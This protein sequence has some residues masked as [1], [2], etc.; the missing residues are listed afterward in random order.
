MDYYEIDEF[1]FSEQ[2]EE[3]I[4]DGACFSLPLPFENTNGT[5]VEKFFISAFDYEK[6]SELPFSIL[7]CDCKLG[8]IIQ[9]R[10]LN[11][12]EKEKIKKDEIKMDINN[13]KKHIKEIENFRQLYCK[14]KDF[15]YNKELTDEEINMLSVFYKSLLVINEKE[16]LHNYIVINETFFQW[17]KNFSRKE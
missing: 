14:V 17:M 9:Y 12:W 4:K 13:H 16:E 15:A 10:E 5:V 3:H 7:V 1:M 11:S 6:K 2:V 8:E